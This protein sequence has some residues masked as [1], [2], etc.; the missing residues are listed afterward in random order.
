MDYW[1]LS[2]RQ[3]WEYLIYQYPESSV[4]VQFETP[5]GEYNLA[6]FTASELKKL[7][8]VD[9][10]SCRYFVTN[11]RF[12]PVYSHTEKIFTIKVDGLEIMTIFTV[13]HE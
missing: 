2:Y 1:G 11:Y 6:W 5:P 13:S 9:Y 8:F 10:L 7:H 4:D 12:H 3:A